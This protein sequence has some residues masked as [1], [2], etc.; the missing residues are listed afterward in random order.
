LRDS[1]TEAPP[2]RT[3]VI[4]LA[5]FLF[6]LSGACTYYLLSPSP[7]PPAPPPVE[8]VPRQETADLPVLPET[9][10]PP[11]LPIVPWAKR[12]YFKVIRHP[13]YLSAAEGDRLLF[14]AEP[15]LGLVLNGEVRAYPTNQLNEH[16]LVIDE[17]AGTPVLVTY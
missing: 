12:G 15:V 3:L 1:N 13:R 2:V 16:E 11:E 5:G 17:V 14:A 8:P 9:D 7:A 4:C 10:P 6:L